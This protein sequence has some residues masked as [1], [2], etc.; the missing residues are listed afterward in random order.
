M[1]ASARSAADLMRSLAN[2]NR[3]M[4]LCQLVD[5]EKSV[6]SL[7]DQLGVRQTLVSQQLALLRRAGL[8][9]ARRDGQ[10]IFY[11]LA[12]SEAERVLGLL[13]DIYCQPTP[14]AAATD[15]A[16]PSQEGATP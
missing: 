3:L 4:L 2:E 7:A 14:D 10:T 13:Y 9:E 15:A 12:S 8:V 11:A 6:G 16:A 5:G 1:K